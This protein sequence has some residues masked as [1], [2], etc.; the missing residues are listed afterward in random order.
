MR[1]ENEMLELILGT[2]KEDERIRA[3]YMNGSR[4]NPNVKKDCYQDYDIV[5]V[6]KETKS[7]Y[8]EEN[9]IDRF[10]EILSLQMPERMDKM[11]GLECHWEDTYGWLMLFT[12]GNRIDLHVNSIPFA[13]KEIGKDRLC[14]I[15]LDKDGILPEI[16]ES[17]DEDYWVRKPAE[18][19]F[20]CECNNFWWCLNNVAKGIAREEISYVMDM[21]NY[22]IRPCL[23][24]M[25]SWSIGVEYDFT[26]SVGKSGKFLPKFLS[27][28]R[29]QNF[30]STYSDADTEHLWQAVFVMCD[31]FHETAMEA[32]EKLNIIYNQKEEN[33]ARRYL[34]MIQQGI[35]SF[36][37]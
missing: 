9:W 33:G 20:L 10:G 30:L 32:V 24:H 8:Q 21:I 1:S 35:C 4:V 6:V 26:V 12:D 5:Y 13:Q 31:L 34:R 15:L 37:R 28:E 36:E 29:Y 22:E 2:A 3:V 27:E 14:R 7:F 18:A 19:D 25:I 23:E 17:T 11:R 16:S